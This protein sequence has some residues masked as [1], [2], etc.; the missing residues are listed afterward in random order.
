MSIT[1]TLERIGKEEY[2]R[3]WK[4]AAV[5]MSI[6]DVRSSRSTAKLL[7]ILNYALTWRSP[8]HA[9]NSMRPWETLLVWCQSAVMGVDRFNVGPPLR[10]EEKALM[11]FG[12]ATVS[13]KSITVRCVPALAPTETDPQYAGFWENNDSGGQVSRLLTFLLPSTS[14][15]NLTF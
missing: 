6:N 5:H 10:W 8:I 13:S 11:R 9:C 14:P 2:P 4:D 15:F 3:G 1:T 7:T 12:T